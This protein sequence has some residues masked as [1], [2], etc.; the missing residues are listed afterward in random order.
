MLMERLVEVQQLYS[1]LAKQAEQ[2]TTLISKIQTWLQEHQ[3]MINSSTTWMAE[4]QSWLVAPC[5]YTTAKCLSSHVQAL[6]RVLDDSAQI[7]TTLQGF[8]SVLKEM[9]QVCDIE[10]LQ[11]QLVEADGQVAIVQ[12]SFTAPLSQLEHAA[13]E[14]EAIESEVKRMQSELD[15]IKS[16]LLSPETLTKPKE[17]KLKVLGKRIQ[18]MRRT[19]AEIQKC[20]PDLCLPDGAE[21][22]LSV[23]AVVDQ[24]QILLLELEKKVP[25]LFIQLPPTPTME[26]APEF[27][28]ESQLPKSS[29]VEPEMEKLEQGQIRIARVE[30]DI[31]KKSGA[32]LQTVKH[33]SPEQGTSR[34]P[35]SFQIPVIVVQ[36]ETE[37]ASAQTPDP[38][39][40]DKQDVE[41]P[42]DSTEA[43][44]SQPLATVTTQSL[45]DRMVNR[46]S[47]P[48]SGDQQKCVVS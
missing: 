46:A 5:T 24:L 44:S 6:Q 11:A 17:E 41:P 25:A 38:H 27:A 1:Q 2:R 26:K 9:S 3:E 31:L 14:V 33:S 15:E 43:S 36:E 18:S 30:P 32:K 16:L 12:E 19:V 35:G 47:K 7:R 39:K 42:T 23:F 21:D 29:S 45:P 34:T 37:A 22:T 28:S 13:A 20:K 4:A 48:D 8:S 10:R 40:R